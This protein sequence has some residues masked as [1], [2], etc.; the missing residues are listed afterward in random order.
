[1]LLLALETHHSQ[2][3][4]SSSLSTP[5][6]IKLQRT[7]ARAWSEICVDRSAVESRVWLGEIE[8]DLISCFLKA[9]DTRKYGDRG[10]IGQVP[11]YMKIAE[12][13]LCA[14]LESPVTRDR[15]AEVAGVSIR[16]LSRAFLKRYGMGPVGFLKQRRLDAAYRNL[17]G[18][19]P[20]TSRVTDVAIRYGFVHMGKFSI[21]YKRAFGEMPSTSLSR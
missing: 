10:F 17:L 15:L 12:D 21:D 4:I 3:P 2:L 7:M 6:G 20:N 5:S 16:T 9:V 8:D 13:F 19:E 1:M 18:A 14:N 11:G